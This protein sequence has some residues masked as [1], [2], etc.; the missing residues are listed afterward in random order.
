MWDDAT[1]LLT[2]PSTTLG[3]VR[4]T[5]SLNAKSMGVVGPPHNLIVVPRSS[6]SGVVVFRWT[7]DDRGVC[8]L[9]WVRNVD[10]AGVARWSM[11]DAVDIA[12]STDDGDDSVALALVAV[13]AADCAARRS[14][15]IRGHRGAHRPRHRA[16][17]GHC[18]VR[19]YI[20]QDALKVLPLPF[21]NEGTVVVLGKHSLQLVFTAS[22]AER[23][24]L[25]PDTHS[26][27]VDRGCCPGRH[28]A[29][30]IRGYL[31][32]PTHHVYHR[33]CAGQGGG[34]EWIT[35]RGGE[36][37]PCRTRGP[38]CR[39][40]CTRGQERRWRRGSCWWS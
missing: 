35:Q 39:A 6:A 36:A 18:G 13:S 8:G 28:C 31:K 32:W 20:R 33:H 25:T 10:L 16:P 26:N 27:R 7:V 11:K 1:A 22:G 12:G 37:P 30:P 14:S 15:D 29:S 38:P 19:I 24:G 34:K 9:A 40:G 23:G 17:A 5:R 3:P 2:L 4:A 21:P